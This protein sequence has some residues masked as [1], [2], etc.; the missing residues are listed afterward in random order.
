[1]AGRRE[2]GDRSEATGTAC[3]AKLIIHI[4]G[5]PR[6]NIFQSKIFNPQVTSDLFK[7]SERR[8]KREGEVTSTFDYK[9]NAY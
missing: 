2:G 8:K 3:R 9:C 7:E 1:M 5:R 6:Q 4:T